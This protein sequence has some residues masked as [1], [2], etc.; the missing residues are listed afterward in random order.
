[1]GISLFPD[2]AK[3]P[4]SSFML[5]LTCSVSHANV[6]WLHDGDWWVFYLRNENT[7][8]GILVFAKQ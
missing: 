4:H 8:Y 1:M 6:C 5:G 3:E 7:H 2:S